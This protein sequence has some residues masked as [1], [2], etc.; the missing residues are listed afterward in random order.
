MKN[1]YAS[2]IIVSIMA[3]VGIGPGPL[4]TL[5]SGNNAPALTAARAAIMLDGAVSAP[6]GRPVLFQQA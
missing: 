1:L 5:A 4:T 3:A 2:T 6:S